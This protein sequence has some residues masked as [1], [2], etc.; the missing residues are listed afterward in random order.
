VVHPSPDRP[1]SPRQFKNGTDAEVV[2]EVT[3]ILRR[4]E[5]FSRV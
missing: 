5:S 1:F 3:T 4:L 2:G